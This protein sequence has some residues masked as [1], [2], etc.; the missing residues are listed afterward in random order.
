MEYNQEVWKY[1]E[2]VLN[3]SICAGRY[4]ILA[5]QRQRDD[6]ERGAERGLLFDPIAGQKMLRFFEILNLGPGV[7][8]TLQPWQ[9]F[10]L[11]VFYG[12]K[13]RHYNAN[14]GKEELRR[15]FN[16]KYKTVSRKNGKTPLEAGQI[17]YHLALE[18]LPY[19]EA[20]VSATKEDQ[21]KLTF[22]D[23]K[24]ILENT[25]A[26]QEV[27]DSTAETIFNRKNGSFFR[28][29]TSNPK[30]ADGTRPSMYVIDEYH[31]FANDDM[32]FKLQTGT[33]HR[34][35]YIASIVTT[36]G[37]RTG[38]AC[39]I[40]EQ[41]VYIPIL[42]GENDDEVFVW[43]F[44]Q[45]SDD[46]YDKPETWRK[47]NPMLGSILEL[48][49]MEADK[50][51]AISKGA[52]AVVSFKA[53]NL[54]MWCTSDKAFIKDSDWV[55]SGTNFSPELLKGRE[56]WGG[57]DMASR[58]DFCAFSL[59][60]PPADDDDVHRALWWFWI[61]ESTIEQRVQKGLVSIRDWIEKEYINTVEGEVIN[62]NVI[63][64]DIMTISEEF[65]IQ[66]IAYDKWNAHGVVFPLSEN[67]FT[68]VEYSQTLAFFTG[69]TKEFRNLV[70]QRK[71]DHGNNPVMRWMVRNS[72][73]I[74][75]PNEN[76]RVSKNPKLAADKVD[77]VIA[78]IMALGVYM[79]DGVKK[80]DSEPQI[81]FF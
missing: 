11:Y 44:S 34:R 46:E 4:E 42:E 61:P 15:R 69:P 27:L 10:E 25:P 53:L 43:I 52:E 65:N 55:K 12:W 41:R 64:R 32:I 33:I 20:Y 13:K 26:L 67:G 59:Y 17:L 22:K 60:F 19:A 49:R 1:E 14:T 39:H 9:K 23:A 56:C 2:G 30:T 72:V 70:L 40:A 54:N 29:L 38:T 6:L 24:A 50:K 75:D 5:V 8:F 35:E 68:M 80:K 57:L 16:T 47:S 79:T 18:G 74:S 63:L 78:G 36:R 45:D 48:S 37:K 73:T 58:D 21:A 66:S 7:P 31:E 51:K 76:I 62:P 77:G 28:F 3:G 81:F 71:Y